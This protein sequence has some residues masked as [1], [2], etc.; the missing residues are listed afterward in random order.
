MNTLEAGIVMVNSTLS[1][2]GQFGHRAIEWYSHIMSV[3]D[4]RVEKWPLMSSPFPVI[5][6]TIGYISLCYM[7]PKMPNKEYIIV[8]KLLL[9]YNLFNVCLNLYIFYELFNVVQHYNW[10]CEPVDYSEN[11]IAL[12]AASALWWYFISKLIDFLDTVFII[13]R[14]KTR[15][16][17]FL[18]VYHHS[19]MFVLWW[20]G[21]KYVAGGSSAFG[22]CINSGVHVLMYT[23]Y[24]ICS[25]KTNSVVLGICKRFKKYLTI[26][27]MLQF[28]A[29]MIMG[30]NALRVGCPFP[31]WMQYAM[32]FYMV[33]FLALFGNFYISR[34]TLQRY[35]KNN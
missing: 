27:Q 29:A 24:A 31:L 28:V 16:L 33:T 9:P 5:L 34:Y 6:I 11:E 26:L 8:S 25:K 30:L 12:R 1:I 23:Y 3:A 4:S 2:P 19:T 14:G 21:V 7:V 18:H 10:I 35:D 22:A 13:L 32:I 20:I 17:T 15:Q